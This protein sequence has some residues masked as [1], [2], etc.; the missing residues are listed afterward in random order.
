MTRT[1]IAEIGNGLYAKTRVQESILGAYL[2]K[3]R[4]CTHRKRDPRGMCYECGQ[5]VAK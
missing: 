1:Q 2:R 3:Q 4:T 5:K